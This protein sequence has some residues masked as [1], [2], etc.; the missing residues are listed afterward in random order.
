MSVTELIGYTIGTGFTT[1]SRTSISRASPR[2]QLVSS[3]GIDFATAH[4]L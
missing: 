2:L 3:I 4:H 1:Y